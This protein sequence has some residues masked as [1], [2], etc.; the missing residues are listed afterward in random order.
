MPKKKPNDFHDS[1]DFLEMSTFQIK[2]KHDWFQV[3]TVFGYPH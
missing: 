1:I 3:Q 2:F